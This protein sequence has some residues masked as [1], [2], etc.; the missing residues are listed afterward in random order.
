[1][2]HD[3][4]RYEFLVF[5]TTLDGREAQL[6][7]RA[8]RVPRPIHDNNFVELLG[9]LCILCDLCGDCTAY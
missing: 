7:E 3:Y 1:M 8:E 6:P 4:V 2:K 5:K 9:F